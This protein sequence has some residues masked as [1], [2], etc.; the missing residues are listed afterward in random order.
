MTDRTKEKVLI[1]GAL[2]HDIGKFE[3]R[4][5]KNPDKKKHQVLGVDFV[6]SG[7]L[8]DKFIRILGEDGF[9]S[10]KNIISEHHRSKTIDLTGIVQI[11]DHLSAS[12]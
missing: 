12:E 5:T 4:C 2:F 7:L 10:F 6:D 8:K 9:N 3:Q 1:L 11:A